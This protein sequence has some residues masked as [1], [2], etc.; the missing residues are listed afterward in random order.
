MLYFKNVELAEKYRVSLGT[1]RN[2]IE[3]AQTNKSDLEVFTENDR[4][5]IVNTASNIAKMEEMV[6]KR[7]KYRNTKAVK[8]VKPQKRFY[9]LF[10]EEQ[11]YDIA[12]GLEIHHEVPL[13]Y[14]YFDNGAD[15]WNSYV[16]RLSE[17][18]IENSFNAA[19]DLLKSNVSMFDRLLKK[20]KRINIVDIGAGNAMPAKCVLE[21]LLENNKLGRYMAIDI[22]PRMLEIAEKNIKKWFGNKVSFEGYVRN[23]NHDRFADLLIPEYARADYKETVNVILHLGYTIH[24]MQRPENGYRTI[25][26]S[27]GKNDLLVEDIKLDSETS[28]TYFDFDAS[29]SKGGRTL[30]PLNE[31]VFEL[32]N[33]DE[34]LYEV[35]LGYDD[36]IKQ[37]YERIRFT[38]AIDLEIDFKHGSRIVSLNKGDTIL[39]WRIFHMTPQDVLQEKQRMGFHV[40]LSSQSENQLYMLTIS[41]VET[42]S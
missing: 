14:N 15:N 25:Y 3:A 28:R 2:W 35:E 27:I 22:S 6:K 7:R 23:V 5:Y 10:T 33:L 13:Q 8:K 37:R 11:I 19:Q 36:T 26:D 24:N 40:M 9:E 21:Y 16:N 29:L 34:S 12:T 42:K 17:E 32:W 38:T 18:D 1:I 39:M 30:S 41:K 20:Y 4:T 31:L